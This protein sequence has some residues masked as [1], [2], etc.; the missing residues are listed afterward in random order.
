MN[1][2]QHTVAILTSASSAATVY[3]PICNGRLVSI[4]LKGGHTMTSGGTVVITNEGTGESLTTTTAGSTSG[5]L[6]YPRASC[7]TSTGGAIKPSTGS[8]VPVDFILS[9]QRV[10]A[11]MAGCGAAKIGTLIVT[12]V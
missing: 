10:K 2:Q 8:A 5:W 6:K 9:Q 1:V 4:Q 3:T 12:V 11:V 7:V